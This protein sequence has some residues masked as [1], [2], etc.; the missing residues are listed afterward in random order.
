[1]AH[2]ID[3]IRSVRFTA[4]MFSMFETLKL[5]E[6]NQIEWLSDY[7]R[8]C[9]IAR[10]KPLGDITAHLPWNI[11]ERTEKTQVYYERVFC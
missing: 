5:W 2:I 9:A 6:I 8:A 1:M 11:R 7:F 4:M 3:P 10:G